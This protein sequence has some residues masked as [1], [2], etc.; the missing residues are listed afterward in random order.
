MKLV[1]EYDEEMSGNT[2]N[3]NN[4]QQQEKAEPDAKMDV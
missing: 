2:A 4:E 3:E 1:E